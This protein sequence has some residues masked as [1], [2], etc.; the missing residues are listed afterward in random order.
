MMRSGSTWS[1]NIALKLLRACDTNRRAFGV[2]SED[3]AVLRASV[4]P[5]S[6]NLVIK[7]HALDPSLYP[8]CST[9]AIKTIYTW[10]NPYDVIV[11]SL[12]M[13]GGSTE[14]WTEALKNALRIWSFHRRTGSACVVSY[15]TIVSRPSSAIARIAGYLGLRVESED[16]KE[17]AQEFSFASVKNFSDAI[18]QLTPL[19]IVRKNGCVYD[20]DT[21][22]HQSHL[23]DGGIGYGVASLSEAEVLAIDAALRE[24]GFGFL[25]E[26]EAES[27]EASRFRL[28]HQPVV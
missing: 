2:F 12:R 7:S 6:S 9:G 13:F 14:R 17:I 16:V 27:T 19:R 11:S 23:R 5:R 4:R 20:R 24:Q 26:P 10:R 15:S 18:N 1:F 8:L 21:L 3:P 25:C 28:R 22:L